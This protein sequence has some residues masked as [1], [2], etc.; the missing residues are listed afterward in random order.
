MPSTPQS[1][2]QRKHR[3]TKLGFHFLFVGAFAMLGGAYRTSNLLLILAGLIFGALV[4]QWR[5]SR[6]SAECV[7]IRR[8]FPREAFAGKPFRVRYRFT[9]V[10]RL[11]AIWTLR[12]ED[13]IESLSGNAKSVAI[14]GVGRLNPEQTLISYCDCLFTKR[15]RYR[16]GPIALMTTFPFSLFSSRQY[17]DATAEL[18]VF[19]SLLKLRRRWQ[20]RLASRSGGE[21]TTARQS[22]SVEGDFFGLREWQTGDSRKWIHWRTT[23]R[24]GEPAVR[25][26]EQQRRF[27]TC[28]LVDAFCNAPEADENV[29]LAI[30]LSATFLT[31]L[32]SSP[33]NRMVL[34]CAGTESSAVI[35]GGSTAGK[36][37]MLELL[38][39]L[40]HSPQP[41]L[42]AAIAKSTQIVGRGQDLLVISPRSLEEACAEND[43]LRRCCEPWMRTGSFRW[44]NVSSRELDQWVASPRKETSISKKQP[45]Q[46]QPNKSSVELEHSSAQSVTQTSGV[47]PHSAPADLDTLTD[48]TEQRDS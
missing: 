27:D 25:Q 7:G 34:A 24:L 43:T 23:A 2:T 18:H 41:D 14:S 28:I 40:K 13:E 37:R 32:S 45:T 33:S 15:G 29:E 5:W 1:D 48:A 44:I 39:E 12:V 20:T 21:S 47:A 46:T 11:I 6:K 31:H 26:F 16:F 17:S 35:G 36:R 38:S 8:R 42:Q 19:P 30:S 4:M 9:N 10:S 3:L 22:G